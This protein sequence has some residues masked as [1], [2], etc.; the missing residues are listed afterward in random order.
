MVGLVITTRLNSTNLYYPIK[1][2]LEETKER[3]QI[4][5]KKITLSLSLLEAR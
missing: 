1:R 4:K 5:F 2:E 3:I